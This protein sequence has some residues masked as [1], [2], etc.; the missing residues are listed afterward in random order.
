M[1]SDDDDVVDG[2]VIKTKSLKKKKIDLNRQ[3]NKLHDAQKTSCT[4]NR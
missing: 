2:D 4:L 1:N 3:S